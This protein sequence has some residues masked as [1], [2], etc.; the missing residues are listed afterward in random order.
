MAPGQIAALSTILTHPLASAAQVI[1]YTKRRMDDR[2]SV[3]FHRDTEEL[4]EPTVTIKVGEMTSLFR[5]RPVCVFT[6]RVY[7]F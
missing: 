7:F 1:K 2:I 5:L 4:D 3:V 6:C